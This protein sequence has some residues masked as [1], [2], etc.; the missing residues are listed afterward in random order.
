MSSSQLKL[1]KLL[2]YVRRTKINYRFNGGGV[3]MDVIFA[4]LPEIKKRSNIY[5]YMQSP[6]QYYY[7]LKC[8][9]GLSRQFYTI[10]LWRSTVRPLFYG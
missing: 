8:L 7:Y 4:V 5:K 10:F 2:S 6:E 1:R 3:F 9:F